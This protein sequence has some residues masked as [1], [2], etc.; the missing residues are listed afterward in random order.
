[1]LLAS[2]LRELFAK[3]LA[4]PMRFL[5]LMVNASALEL[6]KTV[7]ASL[8]A[9]L[10]TIRRPSKELMRFSSLLNILRMVRMPSQSFS[11]TS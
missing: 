1:V 9:H 6:T 2:N 10:A 3:L 7:N 5:V 11:Q 4:E 8:N